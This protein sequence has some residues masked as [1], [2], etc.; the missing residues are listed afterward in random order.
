MPHKT[1]RSLNPNAFVRKL[2]PSLVLDYLRKEKHPQTAIIEAIVGESG[3]EQPV[4]QVVDAI[5]KTLTAEEQNGRW[6]KDEQNFGQLNDL[7][8]PAGMA[9]M[10]QACMDH[11]LAELIS[12]EKTPHEFALELWRDYN[13]VFKH[14][15][16]TVSFDHMTG[17]QV[18]A[19]KEPSEVC[20]NTERAIQQ[21]KAMIQPVMQKVGVGRNLHLEMH[22]SF[23]TRQ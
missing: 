11:N 1:I 13:T 19:G 15:L 14:A 3:E 22:P 8:C 23:Q 9:A 21:F 5:V 6:Q 12:D 16:M 20:E 18:F 2:G 17:W 7:A 4:S 10:R